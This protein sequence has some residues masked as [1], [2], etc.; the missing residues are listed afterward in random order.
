MLPKLCLQLPILSHPGDQSDSQQQSHRQGLN[1]TK[2]RDFR[3]LQELVELVLAPNQKESSIVPFP[4]IILA[5]IFFHLSPR[6]QS[7]CR[8]ILYYLKQLCR[9][10]KPIPACPELF[11]R[12]F[13]NECENLK[14]PNRVFY[15]TPY[16]LKRGFVPSN[17]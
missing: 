12:K 15:V 4:Y 8:N 14:S 17:S 2:N 13:L 1:R 16:S 5:M 10:Q 9:K 7:S 6:L 3:L 11:F